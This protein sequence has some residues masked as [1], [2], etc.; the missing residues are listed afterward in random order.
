MNSCF[1]NFAS[2][3]AILTLACAAACSTNPS[4]Q[5]VVDKSTPIICAKLKECQGA[6]FTLAYPGDVDE[7]VTKTKAAASSKYGGDLGKSSVC[8]DDELDKCLND[9]KAETC[10]ADGSAPAVPCNC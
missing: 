3:L 1:R 9:F 4:A 2:V 10:P 5:E 7:C 6:A 8:T